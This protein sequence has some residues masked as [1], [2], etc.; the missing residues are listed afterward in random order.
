ML[1]HSVFFWLRDDINDEK[2]QAFRNG[3]ESLRGV[4]VVREMFVGV[5]A[6][7]PSRP[8]LVTDYDFALTVIMDDMAAHDT[9]QSHALHLEFLR[10]F[11]GYWSRVQIYDAV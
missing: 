11:S 3:L 7:S 6:D 1:V 9:Y 5:P 10:E 8:V 4:A 2:R